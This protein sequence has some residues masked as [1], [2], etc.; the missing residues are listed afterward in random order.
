MNF[1][2]TTSSFTL[3]IKPVVSLSCAS[4]PLGY[5]LY[6][7]SV[8]RLIVLLSGFLHTFPSNSKFAI[9]YDKIFV[10][11]HHFLKRCALIFS[12]NLKYNRTHKID[13][14]KCKIITNSIVKSTFLQIIS[15]I[16]LNWYSVDKNY[17]VMR[18]ILMWLVNIILL[19]S[20]YP[21]SFD[22][23]LRDNESIINSNRLSQL[24]KKT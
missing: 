2:Y 20:D 21:V 10:P 12:S 14:M 19:F 23:T 5:A 8:R 24:S 1:H 6:D 9:F 11:I 15:T 17:Y 4:F 13:L 18:L 3:P 16:T 7:V 22:G